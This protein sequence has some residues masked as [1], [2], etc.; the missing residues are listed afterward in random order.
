MIGFE[1]GLGLFKVVT[2][3][4]TELVKSRKTDRQELFSDIVEPLFVQLQPVADNYFDLF[5]HAR[6]LLEKGPSEKEALAD[7]ASAIRRDRE[8]SAIRS[9]REKM[10]QL[11]R[12]VTEMAGQIQQEIKEDRVVDFA[13]AIQRFFTSVAPD[14]PPPGTEQMG[15]PAA[16]L[17]MLADPFSSAIATEQDVI[18]YID[19][20]LAKMEDDWAAIAGCYA[21]VRLHLK[22][23]SRYKV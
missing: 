19:R 4:V 3:Q 6:E 2:E 11:R 10:L 14:P 7:P 22:T 21:R 23:P 1:T 15:S 20:T 18:Q 13:L 17:V 12:Q 5:R 9:D 16:Y 8:A